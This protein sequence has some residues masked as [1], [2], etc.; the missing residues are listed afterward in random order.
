M[1]MHKL[2]NTF[3]R[4]IDFETTGFPEDEGAAVCEVGFVDLDLQTLEIS[5]EWQSFVDPCRPI[6][7]IARAVHHI[8]DADVAGA[9]KFGSVQISMGS[10]T[11]GGILCAH[12]D[13]FERAFYDP[14]QR[15]W[16]DT[17]RCALRA[18]PDVP[19][20]SNQSL[21]YLLDIDAESDFDPN[22]AMPP[23]RALPDAY[24]TAFILR[25][26]LHLR[27]VDRLIEI[28]S[29][30]AL[31]VRCGFGKYRGKTFKE[32]AASDPG[33]LRWLVD[34]SDMGEDVKFTAK[35]YL[36]VVSA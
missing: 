34:K 21:R 26:L 5:N 35:Y 31:L 23:H 6:P 36:S 24:V 3:V 15:Q 2:A 9:Q 25:R 30:P 22:M 18:W 17:Y 14:D 27:P 11:Q 28:S 19:S 32:V 7:P 12:N 20:H 8:S 16:I 4:V 29:Q 10:G 1:S 33:Y 13:R